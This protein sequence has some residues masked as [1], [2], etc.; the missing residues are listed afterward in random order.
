M[1]TAPESTS[2]SPASMRSAVV[3][4]EPDG[5]TR[6]MNS[7]SSTWRSSA[8]TAG[9]SVPGYIFVAWRKRTSA[10]G[11]PS[12]LQRG[13]RVVELAPDTLLGFRRRSELVQAEERGTDDRWGLGVADRDHVVDL[14]QPGLDRGLE[15]AV[16]RSEHAA[17]EQHLDWRVRQL[18]PLQGHAGESDDLVGEMLDDRSCDLVSRGLREH[19]GWQLSEPVLRDPAVV[20]RLGQL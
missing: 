5:P 8:S 20:D 10:I 11:G 19:H 14:P 6:T 2:S 13:D 16:A 1:Y 4:P 7:P 18:E 9:V 15:R 3:L 17:A 12:R